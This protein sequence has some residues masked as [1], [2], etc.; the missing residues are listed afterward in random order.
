MSHDHIDLRSD[1]LTKPTPPMLA[2]MMQAVVG[3][4]AFAEDPTVR[5]LEQ[6]TA[7][8]LGKE[9]GLFVPSGTMANQIALQLHARPGDSVIAE[10]GAHCLRFEAGAASALAGVHIDQIPRS[11]RL[12]DESLAAA[13]RSESLHTSATTL[14]VVENTHN[15]GGGRVL[16]LAET[17][18]IVRQAKSLGLAVHCDG[19][20]LWNAAITL[21]VSEADL[22]AG[23]DTV[24][25]CLSKGLGAPVGSV[26][27][28]PEF[29]VTRARKLRKR[30]GGGMRQ[31]GYLAAAGLYALE[32]HRPRLAQDHAAA[33]AMAAQLREAITLGAPLELNYPDPGTNM[34]YLRALNDLGVR[35]IAMG[36]GWLRAVFHLDAGGAQAAQRAASAVILIAKQ[37]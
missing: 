23:M 32:H 29:M 21:G 7:R 33:A 2:A 20:R 28:G 18:R 1:T 37:A 9:A 35:M 12:S 22:V 36:E 26:L 16:C 15:F 17:H 11:E 6:T 5:A 31:V 13:Y 34:V 19:A 14:L 10:E 3:D 25:V 4:D 24:A 27:C 30:L 8:I